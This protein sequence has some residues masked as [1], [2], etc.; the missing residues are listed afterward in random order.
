M[1]MDWLSGIGTAIGG[2]FGY[3][4]QKRYKRSQC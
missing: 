1:E 4:G 2:L 3:K